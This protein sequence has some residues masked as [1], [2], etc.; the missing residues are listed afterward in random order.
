[1]VE[2]MRR[3]ADVLSKWAAVGDSEEAIGTLEAEIGRCR[4]RLSDALAGLSEPQADDD[5]ALSALLGRA[6][7]VLAGVGK[8]NK[9]RESLESGI[10]MA[11]SELAGRRDELKSVDENFA[12]WRRDWVKAIAVLRRGADAEPTQVDALL[13]E[14]ETLRETL[15]RLAGV[16]CQI[17]GIKRDLAEYAERVGDTIA[18]AAPECAG[19]EPVEAA[20]RM[21]EMLSDARKKAE[22]RSSL[23]EAVGVAAR[24]EHTAKR[25]L[26]DI[27]MILERL[28]CD[29]GCASVDE[30]VAAEQRAENKRRLS[31]QIEEVTR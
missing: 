23:E 6:E 19:V 10:F 9:N 25:E 17:T 26:H 7:T 1:M 8:A 13:T 31:Q 15:L 24:D 18:T 29:A 14:L 20:R 21:A 27:Q 5:E 4:K 3:R 12:R 2:W 16:R 30:L 22:R 28:C 11:E